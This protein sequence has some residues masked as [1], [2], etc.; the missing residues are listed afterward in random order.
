M[1]AKMILPSLGGTSSVWTV[2]ML[3]FQTILLMGY[4]YAQLTISRLGVLRQS[5]MHSLIILIPVAV[6]PA[7]ASLS[8]WLPASSDPTVYLL[9]ALVSHVGL[10]FFVLS[11][12]A[13]M[14][15][16]WFANTTHPAA[17]DPYFLYWASNFGSSIGLL[18]Y[19]FLIERYFNLA[20]QTW[21]WT[22]GY[23]F[24]VALTFVCLFALQ[25]SALIFNRDPSAKSALNSAPASVISMDKPRPSFYRRLRWTA[26]AFAPSSLFLG[27][28]TYIST[29]I[30][31]VP[32]LWIIPLTLYLLS[33]ILVF[34]RQ[35][36]VVQEFLARRLPFLVVATAVTIFS[37]ATNPPWLLIPLH[38]LTVFV[39]AMVCHG[40]LVNDRPEPKH[41]TEFYTWISLGGVAG[42][43]F[44]ALVAPTLF[45]IPLEY[46][47]AMIIAASLIPRSGQMKEHTRL[48]RWL[49]FLLP[50]ILGGLLVGLLT[51]LQSNR[52]LPLRFVHNLIFGLA[53]IV[54]LSFAKRAVRFALALGAVM[55]SSL[56][57]TG[58]YG[59]ILTTA[60]SFFGVHRVMLDKTENY[61]LLLHGSTVHGMQSVLASRRLEPLSYY[62]ASGP[63]GQIFGLEAKDNRALPVG[64]VGLG[65]GSLAC[66]GQP[67]QQFVFYEIDPVVEHIARDRRYF[68]FLSDCPARTTVILGDA[69]ISL[70]RAADHYYGVIVLDAFS[71]DAIPVHL[72]TKEAI[73]LYLSKLGAG[74][75]LAL[76]ISNRHFDLEPVLSDLE[77]EL[78]LFGLIQ[79]DLEIGESEQRNGKE[80]SRWVIMARQRQD[81]AVLSKDARWRLLDIRGSGK[82]WT[83]NFSNIVEVLRWN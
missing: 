55:V 72:L 38:L 67:G 39:A 17:K 16:T 79:N 74:G 18:A 29:D 78:G 23:Y 83:D 49:D 33:F 12:T 82:P 41:L 75:L 21:L 48:I 6:L 4:L 37:H 15:Q 64:I 9:L 28:T 46:P 8:A 19:P 5:I 43:L 73:E 68:T 2:C 54:C 51:F 62:S 27:T 35:S 20:S 69:R 50:L 66:Y 60:R 65:T 10:P 22:H 59:R 32:M 25:R 13:P 14:L 45:A 24:F 63:I 42:G 1:A 26:L 52:S 57:Y 3:F 36:I 47:L 40:E 76:H 61:H 34:G 30:A 56:L 58:P 71:S 53:G 11:T 80:P 7:I 44:N 81:L 77:R 70:R 31:V